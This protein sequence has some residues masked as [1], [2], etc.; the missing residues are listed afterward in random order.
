MNDDL[1]K[2]AK[3]LNLDLAWAFNF[4]LRRLIEALNGVHFPKEEWTG[5]D[6]NP[7]LPP[8]QGGDHTTDLPALKKKLKM[9]A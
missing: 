1:L 7:R 2:R 5:R 9:V 4:C 3:E 8:C 6:L